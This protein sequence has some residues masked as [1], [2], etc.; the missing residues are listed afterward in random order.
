M[1]LVLLFKIIVVG[2]LFN[3]TLLLFLLLL[4]FLTFHLFL[5]SL[6]LFLLFFQ[7]VPD[8]NQHITNLKYTLVL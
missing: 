2:L 4:L 5:L 6:S 3:S 8:I 1:K 7:I